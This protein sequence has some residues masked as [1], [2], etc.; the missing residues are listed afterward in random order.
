MCWP[1]NGPFRA[2]KGPKWGF[3][4]FACSKCIS[5]WRFCI[6]WSIITIS[7]TWYW[8]KYWKKFAGP[9]MGHLGPKRGQ[10][11]V[12]GHYLAQKALVFRDFGYDDSKITK[13]RT[14]SWSKCWKKFVGPKMAPLGPKRGQNEVLGHFHV[15]NALVL[16]NCAYYDRDL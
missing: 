3:R 15:Q 12:L 13:S 16:A 14:W 1:K 2:K 10:N 5:F 9:K 7:R 8:Q 4:P 11:E 6:L